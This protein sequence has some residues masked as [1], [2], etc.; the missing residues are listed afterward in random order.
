MEFMILSSL[1]YRQAQDRGG[2]KICAQAVADNLRLT[3][4]TVE[5]YLAALA[6]KVLVT[7]DYALTLKCKD[8]KFF[9]LPN[10]IFL[11]ALPLSAFLV[12]AYL[13]YCEDRRACPYPCR[14]RWGRSCAASDSPMMTASSPFASSM[15]VRYCGEKR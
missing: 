13:L 4:A 2:K 5:K 6:D 11:L 12:Y 7:E 3:A 14:S 9:T 10:E 8:G 15:G 1:C